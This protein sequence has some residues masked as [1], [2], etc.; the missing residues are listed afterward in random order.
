MCESPIGQYVCGYLWVVVPKMFWFKPPSW[1]YCVQRWLGCW[2]QGKTCWVTSALLQQYNSCLCD[3]KSYVTL[4]KIRKT[5]KSLNK[6]KQLWLHS[7]QI[8][9]C[10]E[11]RQ[12]CA[13]AEVSRNYHNRTHCMTMSGPSQLYHRG[14]RWKWMLSTQSNGGQKTILADIPLHCTKTCGK[15]SNINI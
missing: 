12:G 6:S 13:A 11:S 15:L 2:P 3:S 14:S 5:M 10:N 9:G 1:F 7:H 4:D 8:W